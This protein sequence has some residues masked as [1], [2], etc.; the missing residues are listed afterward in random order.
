MDYFDDR[1]EPIG[2]TTTKDG[3]ELAIEVGFDELIFGPWRE[4]EGILLPQRFR[5]L[6]SLANDRHHSTSSGYL[7][8][9]YIF[10]MVDGV[11]RCVLAGILSSATAPREVRS[12]DLRRV[13]I[14]YVLEA[15]ILHMSKMALARHRLKSPTPRPAETKRLVKKRNAITDGT[16][17]E[18]AKVYEEN[19]EDAPT[20][21]VADHFGIQLRTASLRV[22]MARDAGHITKT[23]KAGRKPK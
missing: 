13:R 5:L 23:A 4:Y 9:E 21:S 1:L 2:I 11:P 17:R 15:A 10:E 8:A 12:S 22:K 7:E 20:Q 18:V 3:A 14:E 19:L 6:E 16:L